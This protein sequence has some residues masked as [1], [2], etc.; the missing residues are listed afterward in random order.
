LGHDWQSRIDAKKGALSRVG[1]E[2]E[3]DGPSVFKTEAQVF[4]L[5]VGGGKLSGRVEVKREPID[6]VELRISGTVYYLGG[7]VKEATIPFHKSDLTGNVNIVHRGLRIEIEKDNYHF[8]ADIHLEDKGDDGTGTERPVGAV[9]LFT[10]VFPENYKSYNILSLTTDPSEDEILDILFLQRL[11]IEFSSVDL[12]ATK[13][14]VQVKETIITQS[15][16]T[17]SLLRTTIQV[18]PALGKALRV[19]SIT[20]N[21][22]LEINI[23]TAPADDEHNL[24]MFSD[25][26]KVILSVKPDPESSA[27][28]DTQPVGITIDIQASDSIDAR[29]ELTDGVQT[30]KMDAKSEIGSVLTSITEN[31]KG[32]II[33]KSEK[34]EVGLFPKKGSKSVII[35][36]QKYKNFIKAFKPLAPGKG[37]RGSIYLESNE[38]NI[39]DLQ[40]ADCSKDLGSQDGDITVMVQDRR[41]MIWVTRRLPRI[42]SQSEI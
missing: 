36:L 30:L 26:S 6:Q 34:Q 5:N 15:I 17:R 20:T 16:I 22:P 8:S 10:I 4:L 35:I 19:D 21:K 42:L 14:E 41:L 25:K 29:I 32:D 37:E 2:V 13:G 40:R 38:G 27:I 33:L 9:L 1:T 7:L 18:K 28:R 31:Y 11:N 3:W 39:F 23:L 24:L 12:Q